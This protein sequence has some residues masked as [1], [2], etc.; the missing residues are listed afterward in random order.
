M[1]R[2]TWYR[3][4]N[5]AK[6]YPP[7]SSAIRPGVFGLSAVLTENID[8]NILNDAVNVVL[9]RFPSFKV[10][11][12]RGIFWYYL[13]ENK[14]PFYVSE[15]PPYFLQYINE[16]ESNDYLFRVFYLN[17]KITVA[18]FH[19]L[20]DGTGGMEFLKALIFEYLLL[21]GYKI[22][23]ENELKT[24]YSPVT[25]E[26][27]QDEFLEVYDKNAPKMPKELP[28]YKLN[29]TGFTSFGV[30][31]INA[32]MPI[33]QVKTLAKK[34]NST[35]TTFFTGLI[36]HFIYTNYIKNKNVKNKNVRILIPVNMRKFYNAKTIRNFAL[37]VRP[38]CDFVNELT[39]EEC[40]ALCDKQVKESAKKEILDAML[41]AN[42]KT[43]KNPILKITPLFLKD[44][45]I[46]LAYKKIGDNL[47]TTTIS[48]LGII[49]LPPS[50][51]KYVKDFTFTLGTSFSS[52]YSIGMCSYGD[53]LN[54]TFSREFVETNIEKD[55]VRYL[56]QNGVQVELSSNYWEDNQ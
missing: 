31:I 14:K 12:K 49:S 39:L 15:E 42:V 36:L 19:A 30:G 56:T 27:M 8:K 23:A 3:L 2:K 11:L 22:K 18:I 33:E 25:N 24:I 28:A 45:A 50:V 40:I 29:G 32:R 34:Y 21:K 4:D 41:T 35:I 53:Y 17:N 26:E 20:A 38:G 47:H 6:V 9:H 7:I 52:K 46:Q 16:I 43:E 51:Q 37:F 1:K 13:E 10:K 54:I 5:A 44:F 55:F 48:N